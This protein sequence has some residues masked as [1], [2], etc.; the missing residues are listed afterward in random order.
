MSNMPTTIWLQ[1]H[2]SKCRGRDEHESGP[3]WCEDAVFEP[4]E[5]CGQR[6]VQYGQDAEIERLKAQ[7]AALV[8]VAKTYE[9]WE[10][11]VIHSPEA[12]AP[13]GM[14]ET[15]TLTKAQWGRLIEIQGMRNA[16]LATDDQTTP[17]AGAAA[18]AAERLRQ[19]TQ[20]GWTADHDDQHDRGELADAAV[21]YLL[22]G[23][24]A[25][26]PDLP[27][28]RFWPWGHSWWKPKDRRHDLVRAGALIAAEIDRLDRA[29]LANAGEGV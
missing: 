24:N 28:E 17:S 12:W 5:E 20:E 4:C 9:E 6:P 2:C 1:P 10:A 13:C 21:T 15:P 18:I 27:F 26:G 11:D 8:G 16:A 25:P 23:D 19:V 29:A 22:F 7:N 14:A 3:L